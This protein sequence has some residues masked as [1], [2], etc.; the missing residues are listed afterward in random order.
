MFAETLMD[1]RR[2]TEDLALA[3][4]NQEGRMLLQFCDAKHI[5]IA[6]TWFRKA[7]KRKITFGPGCNKREIDF[8]II[9][10]VDR[11]L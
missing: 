5:C 2:F 8:C 9:G 10:K 7:D 1:S 3:E 6:E 11:M 4:K